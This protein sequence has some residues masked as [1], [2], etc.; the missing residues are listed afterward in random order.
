MPANS[1]VIINVATQGVANYALNAGVYVNGQ[2]Q[3]VNL[4]GA[5]NTTKILFNFPDAVGANSSVSL[6]AELVGAV[7]APFTTLDINNQVGGTFLAG[8]INTNGETHYFAFD[9]NLPAPQNNNNTITPEPG[10]ML[11]TCIGVL[12][13]A[14]VVR[15]RLRA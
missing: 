7:L 2:Q 14:G 11:L 8:N 4:N 1:T 5:L 12:S 10:T 13:L 9:G 15:R 3:N 6:D